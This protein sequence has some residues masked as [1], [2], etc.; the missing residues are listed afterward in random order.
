MWKVLLVPFSWLYGLVLNVRHFLYDSG[1]LKSQK[2]VVPTLVIGNLCAG[3]SGKTPHIIQFAHWISEFHAIA[4]LSRGYGRKS[5]GFQWVHIDSTPLQAGDEPALMKKHL[6]HLPVAVCNNRLQGIEQI[7]KQFP[8]TDFVLLDDAYQHRQLV[9]DIAV[10]L[11]PYADLVGKRYLL[12]AGMQRDLWKRYKKADILIVTRCLELD[13]SL[14][15]PHIQQMLPGYSSDAVFLSQVYNKQVCAFDS[16]QPMELHA[17]NFPTCVL[18]TGIAGAD[19]LREILENKGIK[20]Q[21]FEFADHYFF[22]EEDVQKIIVASAQKHPIFTTGKDR[23]KIEALLESS[24]KANWYELLLELRFDR[25]EDLKK[26][27][28]EHVTKHKRSR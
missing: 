5:N 24:L 3:G 9:S 7:V 2:A 20:V 18:V 26:L 10:L 14:I 19:R 12:P 21:H 6:P 8:E 15:E 27:V 25:K 13:K 1:L 22:S 16:S 11:I 4:L 17:M 28:L 23:V